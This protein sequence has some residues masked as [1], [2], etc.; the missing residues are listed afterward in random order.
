MAAVAVH[1][2]WKKPATITSH[3]K[4]RPRHD[5]EAIKV[6]QAVAVHRLLRVGKDVRAGIDRGPPTTIVAPLLRGSVAVPLAVAPQAAVAVSTNDV[7]AVI[8]RLPTDANPEAVP[9][10]AR[11]DRTFFVLHLGVDL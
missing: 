4:K 6:H 10:R 2:Q 5:V 3:D 8:L 11:A 9:P 7:A 1:C